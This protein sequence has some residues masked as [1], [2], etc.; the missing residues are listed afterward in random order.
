MVKF[1]TPS[2]EILTPIN[3]VEMLRNIE[4]AGRTCYKSEDL[5]TSESAAKFVKMIVGR[6]HMSVIEHCV[7]TVKFIIPRGVSHELVRHRLASYS[8]ECLSGDTVVRVGKHSITIRDLWSR[9]NG[10]RHDRTHNK[11]I[12]LR[13]MNI[14]GTIVPNKMKDIW[15]KGVQDVYLVKTS[16]GYDI[17]TTMNHRFFTTNNT[18]VELKELAIGD[19][20]L[21]N[22]R[23]SLLHI[24]DQELTTLYNVDGL[25]PTEI[26]NKC[27]AP[28]HSVLSRLSKLGIF[29]KHKNDKHPEKYNK[30]RTDESNKK[31]KTTI[32][33][34]YDNGRATWNQGLK[35][36]QDES[37]HRQAITLRAHHHD[38]QTKENNSAWKGGVSRGVAYDLKKD[39]IVCELCSRTDHLEVHH[40]DGDPSHNTMDNIIKVCINCHNLLHHGWYVGTKAIIDTIT[41]IEYAGKEETFDIEMKRPNNYVANGFIVHNSTRYCNYGKAKFGGEITVI[42]Q[43]PI[44][45]ANCKGDTAKAERRIAAWIRHMEACEVAYIDAINDG[46]SPNN[47][48]PEI[49]RGNLPIDLKTEIVMTANLR[50]WLLIFSQRC[51]PAAHPNMRQVM[52]PLREEF[53]KVLPEIFGEVSIICQDE[54]PIMKSEGSYLCVDLVKNKK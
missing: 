21:V 20:I 3:R 7:V 29:V 19:K 15:N 31:M 28:Y 18:F 42:D 5:I 2:F 9:Q 1:V 13:S 6:A 48:P 49:A 34:Q 41:S 52:I 10:T 4:L 43:Q 23:P 51:S 32:C 36:D 39:I 38:Q 17:K 50:E 33:H 11:T 24:T 37:V 54:V 46:T 8:Q 44:I 14:D 27:D 40:K 45:I 47:F 22:G 30:G 16:L 53:R 25:D 12:H 26:A 35:E